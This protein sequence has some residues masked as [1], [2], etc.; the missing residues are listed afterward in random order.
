MTAHLGL[1]RLLLL[2]GETVGLCDDG[3]D[4]DH[5]A[6]LFHDDHVNGAE[7]VTGGVEEVQAAVDTGVL[8]VA[9]THGGELLA[10]V[11]AVLVLDVLD[12]GVP[13]AR[14]QFK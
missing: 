2:D 1:E 13:A 12:N 5:V 10:E 11:R 6:E 9:V 4:V 14:S 8:D 3:D 7:R